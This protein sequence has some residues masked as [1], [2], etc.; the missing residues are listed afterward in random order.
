MRRSVVLTLAFLLLGTVAASGATKKARPAGAS[1]PCSGGREADLP[2]PSTLS[3]SNDPAAYQRLLFEFLNTRRYRELGWCVDKGLRDTGPYINGTYY[4]THPVVRI[5]YS[6]AAARWVAN[7]R[8]GAIPDRAIIIK[9][10]FSNTPASQWEGKSDKEIDDWFFSGNGD[11]TVMIRDSKGSAD[12]WFWSEIYQK[13]WQYDTYAPT[14]PVFNSGFGLYC[15]RCHATAEK[16]LTF[17]STN[18]MK[19]LPGQP[20]TFRDDQSWRP[21]WPPAV[22]AQTATAVPS[23]H[24]PMLQRG[25]TTPQYDADDPGEGNHPRVDRAAQAALAAEPQS[26]SQALLDY[27]TTHPIGSDFQPRALPGENY[28]HV[29][30]PHG[31]PQLFLTSDQCSGCH[32]G[33]TYGNVMLQTGAN[34]KPAFDYSPYGEWRWSPMGLAGRDPV[35]F[36]QV[37]SEIAFLET[38]G[39]PEQTAKVVNLCFSCHGGMGQRQLQADQGK[40]ALFQPEYVYETDKSNAH[41]NY[42]ALARDG[43]S[44]ALCHHIKRDD[45]TIE[46]FLRKTITGQFQLTPPDQLGGPFEEPITIPMKNGLGITPVHDTYT[47]SS[48]ICGTCHAINLPVLDTASEETI[49]ERS[50]KGPDPYDDCPLGNGHCSFEQAT[51]LEWLNSAFQNELGK[52]GPQAQTCQDCHMKGTLKGDV[53]QTQIAAVQDNHYPASDHSA[54]ISVPYRESGYARH[55]F[56]GLNAFLLG[57]FSQFSNL[58]G[59]RTCSYMASGCGDPKNPFSNIPGVMANFGE[60]A[61]SETAT[62]AAGAPSFARN[63]DGT[64]SLTT[65]VTVT[66]LTVHRFPSGVSFR[67]AI[68]E[69]TVRDRDGK[70]LFGSGRTNAGG[71]IVGA[72]DR[73]LPS[74]YVGSRGPNGHAYQPHY[75]SPGNP[76]TRPDQVQI[77]EEL[78][79]DVN[80]DFTTSFI[81]QDKHFKD[82][83]I[84]PRGWTHDGPD[85]AKFN[86]AVLEETRPDG[87]GADSHYADPLGANGQSVVRYQVALPAGTDTGSLRIEARL[88]YQSVPP[89]FLNQRFEQ[90][91]NM[92]ATQRLFYIVSKF[93]TTRTYG[94]AKPPLENWKLLVARTP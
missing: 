66:N 60:Q 32:A 88:Y 4:G 84:L 80:G 46:Q 12:G 68:I 45:S 54:S 87:V 49:D 9:E 14:F 50:G 23:P 43:V 78:L 39:K 62:I 2:L 75:W 6:P 15:L 37:D 86:N 8:K 69:F 11:W 44:C 26:P 94:L 30:S 77:Y 61:S 71:V 34:G 22:Q 93:D 64:V 10:Q 31:K 35:F 41:F 85:P 56:Q 81:R 55:Q 58:L 42:G 74:E 90:S 16:E 57:F 19:G 63:A 29:V 28:D 36:A 27:L 89:Y 3:K 48:R 47:K 52:P 83:R 18:N 92:P 73:P 65:D 25:R 1:F 76:I 70:L 21:A 59:V 17:S 72:D 38:L 24:A 13:G 91:G 20:L 5:W 51:Y 7:G 33:N 40:N 53:V 82:N 79:K 67:R